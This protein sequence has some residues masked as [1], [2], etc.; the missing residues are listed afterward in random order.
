MLMADEEASAVREEHHLSSDV[1]D[2][3]DDEPTDATK[4]DSNLTGT[5]P[6]TD[7]MD[8]DNDE[9]DDELPFPGFVPVAFRF[10]DQRNRVR[11]W[12]LR[13]ITW[14]YPFSSIKKNTFFTNSFTMG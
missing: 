5:E 10:M 13:C 3:A 11:F 9:D 1:P 4:H 7:D 8:R 2:T 12:C 6:V 14:P